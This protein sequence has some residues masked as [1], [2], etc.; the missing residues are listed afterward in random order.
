MCPQIK[1]PLLSSIL[2][3]E[4]LPGD[5]DTCRHLPFCA[6]AR[7]RGGLRIPRAAGAYRDIRA[8]MERTW[9]PTGLDHHGRA[10]LNHGRRRYRSR[11]EV[12]VSRDRSPAKAADTI[13]DPCWQRPDL[14]SEV[15]CG[16]RHRADVHHPWVAGLRPAVRLIT[17]LGSDQVQDLRLDLASGATAKWG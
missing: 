17:A 5:D 8:N 11:H 13:R 9:M 10:R 12:D 16:S 3:P 15:T 2:L 1:S 14:S 4:L 7:I 6:V